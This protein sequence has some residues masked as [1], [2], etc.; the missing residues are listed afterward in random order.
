[1]AASVADT[2]PVRSEALRA[3]RLSEPRSPALPRP[4][5]SFVGRT[6]QLEDLR[7]LLSA[8]RLVTLTGPAGAGKTRLAL[9]LAAVAGALPSPVLVDLASVPPGSPVDR[10]FAEA[11]G[12]D[13]DGRAPRSPATI[14]PKPEPTSPKPPTWPPKSPTPA[15]SAEANEL[16]AWLEN[17]ES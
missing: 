16:L 11:L 2:R 17:S 13:G 7:R 4:L 9:H 12:V 15:K 8:H 6:E 5:S 1:M 3:A 14:T 10:A